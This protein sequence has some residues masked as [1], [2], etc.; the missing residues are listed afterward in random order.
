MRVHSLLVGVYGPSL[1]CRYWGFSVPPTDFVAPRVE[2]PS[3][4]C[5]SSLH[6]PVLVD[7]Y[8]VPIPVVHKVL[9]IQHNTTRIQKQGYQKGSRLVKIKTK[10]I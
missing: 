5:V 10:K 4:Y 9:C 6:S 7:A 8:S 2:V 1:M 3:D